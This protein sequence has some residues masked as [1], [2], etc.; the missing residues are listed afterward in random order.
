MDYGEEVY[1]LSSELEA[2][3]PGV[4]M[5]MIPFP[6]PRTPLPKYPKKKGNN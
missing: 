5:A 3:I 2:V 1:L 6:A 4:V